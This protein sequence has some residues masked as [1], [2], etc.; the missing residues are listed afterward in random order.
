MLGRA[1]LGVLAAALV[2]AI[3]FGA[4][5]GR[6]TY[7]IAD[8][9][10]AVTDAGDGVLVWRVTFDAE[11]SALGGPP[12]QVQPCTVRLLAADGT[13]LRER[14]F[15]LHVGRGDR[16]ISPPFDF[17]VS[18]VPGEPDRAEVVCSRRG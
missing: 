12:V 13:V 6:R 18:G 16:G 8:V 2:G 15:G 3:V 4:I 17:P 5:D 11:W 1:A 7:E 14:G 9:R 10:L